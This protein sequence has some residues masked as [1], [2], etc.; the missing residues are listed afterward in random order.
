MER[1]RVC[2]TVPRAPGHIRARA[3][4]NVG[5]CCLLRRY[6][7]TAASKRNGGGGEGICAAYS[8]RRSQ[9]QACTH[10][11]KDAIEDPLPCTCAAI[12]LATTVGALIRSPVL[13]YR[14]ISPPHAL[15]VSKRPV[16]IVRCVSHRRRLRPIQQRSSMCCRSFLF[17]GP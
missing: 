14:N 4:P 5:T 2:I 6:V 11:A 17:L 10:P 9:L 7:L 1:A 12:L 16:A 3:R 8:Y 15:Y 13:H